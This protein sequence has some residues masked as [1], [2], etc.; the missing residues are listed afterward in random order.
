MEAEEKQ[1]LVEGIAQ[2]I[3]IGKDKIHITFYY[4]ASCK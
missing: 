3:R 1:R 2:S 4:E